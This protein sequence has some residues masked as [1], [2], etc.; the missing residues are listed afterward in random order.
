VIEEFR[1]QRAE[2][3][4]DIAA[5]GSLC[6]ALDRSFMQIG[7][8]LTS[9]HSPFGVEWGS[10]ASVDAEERSADLHMARDERRFDLSV[11]KNHIEF[12]RGSTPH[13][14][15]VVK[16]IRR[17]FEDREKNPADLV[18]MIPLL[19]L[20]PMAESIESDIR[21]KLE[22]PAPHLPAS[23]QDRLRQL[24]PD[25]VAAG[26]LRAALDRAIFDL[27]STLTSS[28]SFFERQASFDARVKSGERSAHV[29]VALDDR[30]FGLTVSRSVIELA[31][32]WV[33]DLIDVAKAILPWIEDPD[34][35]ASDLARVIPFLELTPK[36]ESYERGY[37][38]EDAW[39]GFMSEP[40]DRENNDI[41]HWD[42]LYQLIRLAAERPELRRL[43]PY[44][45][46]ERFSVAIHPLPDTRIPVIRAMGDG[47]YVLM[48]YWGDELL[49][50]GS[51]SVVLDALIESVI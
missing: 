11:R 3:Y 22:R 12:G 24:Y 19:K 29:Y 35:K 48:P 7:S 18:R 43:L 47:R 39:Q 2:L 17:W 42:E 16:A 33:P 28:S 51:A 5:A 9:S 14:I 40:L 13:L 26:S 41:Y 37:Y 6:V 38:I 46:L 15:D 1:R 50:D 36:A 30:K 27:G 25:V 45:S 10:L 23:E 21:R 49:A 20:E 4:P 44:M 31:S 34:T 8:T 32:G